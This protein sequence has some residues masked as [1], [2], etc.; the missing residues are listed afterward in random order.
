MRRGW[1]VL[2]RPFQLLIVVFVIVW[3]GNLLLHKRHDS[4]ELPVAAVA[5]QSPKDPIESIPAAPIAQEGHDGASTPVEIETPAAAS[6]NVL[7]LA[8]RAA[9]LVASYPGLLTTR[10]LLRRFRAISTAGAYRQLK[11][12]VSNPAPVTAKVSALHAR[13]VIVGPG[14]D[15]TQNAAS[16]PVYVTP[17]FRHTSIA[18]GKTS[19][20]RH[21]VPYTINLVRN[22]RRWVV[23]EVQLSTSGAGSP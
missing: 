7:R 9:V 18:T 20:E 4:Q 19:Y 13:D 3:V 5:T 2:K 14:I 15:R 8:R 23:H 16:V 17:L 22:G 21:V 11:Q 6:G 12:Q 10:Q 1:G